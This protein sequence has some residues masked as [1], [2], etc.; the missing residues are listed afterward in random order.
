MK[1]ILLG[2]LALGL[3]AWTSPAGADPG[4]DAL[5]LQSL[6][7]TADL[8]AAPDVP[9][10][11]NGAPVPMLK[12]C[13]ISRDCGDGNTVAC[14]GTAS[15]IYTPRGVKCDSRY[16]DC[17]HACTMT[18]WCECGNTWKSCSSLYG[19]CGVTNTGCNGIPQFCAFC[20]PPQ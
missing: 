12:A 7:Q 11:S 17:P 20:P 9:A 16:V 13:S 4:T 3:L 15:C 19:D 10:S 14:T 8:P 5:F 2:L 18:Y 1:Q 6:E